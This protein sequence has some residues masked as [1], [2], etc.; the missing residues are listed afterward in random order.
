M[1]QQTTV[2]TVIPYFNNWIKKSPDYKSVAYATEDDILKAW[3]G[4]GYYSR[5]RNLHFS[6]KYIVDK[7]NSNFPNTFQ[8][9]IKLKG[10]GDYTASAISSICFEEKVPAIDGNIFRILSRLFELKESF[11]SNKFK[12]KIKKLALEIMPNNRFGSQYKFKI[13]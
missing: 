5:A 8:D 7:L 2:K 11:Y 13:F 6:A 12:T 4:L 3:E 10:I 9:I 1:L